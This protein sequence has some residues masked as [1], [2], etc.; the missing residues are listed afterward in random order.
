M[1]AI[2][3]VT[4]GTPTSPQKI[5]KEIK[6]VKTVNGVEPDENGNVEVKG[7]PPINSEDKDKVLTVGEDGAPVWK[8]PTGGEVVERVGYGGN[9]DLQIDSSL[10]YYISGYNTVTIGVDKSKRCTAHL[11]VTFPSTISAVGFILPSDLTVYG[12][13]PNG[14]APGDRWEVSIDGVGGALFFRK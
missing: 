4:V 12:E 8:K 14:A 5:E 2:I 7:V 10:V 1:S 3:G 9:L 13:N 6:P 11:F